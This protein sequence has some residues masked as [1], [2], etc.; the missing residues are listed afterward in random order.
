MGDGVECS[1]EVKEDEN[2]EESRVGCTEEIVCDF[3]QGCQYCVLGG[4]LT[5]GGFGL[6]DELRDGEF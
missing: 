3:D 6:V 5:C 4:K 1:A 2:G